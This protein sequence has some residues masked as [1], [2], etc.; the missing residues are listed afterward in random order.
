M[1]RLNVEH[2][3]NE[4]LMRDKTVEVLEKSGISRRGEL[5]INYIIDNILF[6][7]L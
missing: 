2:R 6:I 7:V 3:Y 1:L 4:K 5:C